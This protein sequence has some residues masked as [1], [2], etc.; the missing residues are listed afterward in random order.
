MA[1]DL[2]TTY[3]AGYTHRLDRHFDAS[4]ANTSLTVSTPSGDLR[5]LLYVTVKYTGAAST[6]ITVKINSGAGAAYDILLS[7]VALSADTDFVY[8]P[9]GDILLASNDT[10]DVVAPAVTAVTSAIAIY[11]RVF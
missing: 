8:V 2:K 9:D 1:L 7:S 11:T 4:A 6:T 10:I 5:K 3:Q